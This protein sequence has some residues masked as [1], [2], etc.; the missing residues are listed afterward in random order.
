[1][2]RL[3]AITRP[4]STPPATSG[5]ASRSSTRR[6]RAG[7]CGCSTPRSSGRSATGSSIRPG[8]WSPLTASGLLHWNTRELGGEQVAELQQER[9]PMMAKLAAASLTEIETDPGAARLRPGGRQARLRRQLRALPRRRRR[10][11]QGLSQPERRRLAVGRLARP[12]RANHHPRRARR[13]RCRPSR[14]DAGLRPRRPT[15][16]GRDLDRRRLRALALGT[17]DRRKAPISRAAR[18]SSPTIAPPATGR[19]ARAIARSARR[20]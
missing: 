20:T 5:T 16:A 10:R 17:A 8:R 4:R 18:R 1:M 6:C 19:T 2:P 3:D 9:G 15:Q 12:D 7:G 11:R 14:H 13:R